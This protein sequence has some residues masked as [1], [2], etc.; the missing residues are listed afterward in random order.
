MET[1]R[2]ELLKQWGISPGIDENLLVPH[3]AAERGDLNLFK[4]ALKVGLD[5]NQ[6][7]SPT[8]LVIPF[9]SSCA[10]HLAC[11]GGSWTKLY[12]S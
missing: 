11:P 4:E 9:V 5:P 12:E 6:K 8:T 1:I 10:L 3:I 2:T 7:V